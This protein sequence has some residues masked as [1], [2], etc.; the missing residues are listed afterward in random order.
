[1]L[2]S[3]HEIVKLRVMDVKL[4][5]RFEEFKTSQSPAKCSMVSPTR[6][7]VFF[8]RS[9]SLEPARQL[10]FNPQTT[11]ITVNEVIKIQPSGSFKM[12]GQI[13]WKEA[14]HLANTR[15]GPKS[16][17]DAEFSDAQEN[18]LPLV[19]WGDELINELEHGKSYNFSKLTLIHHKG[20]AKLQTLYDTEVTMADTQL[21]ITWD[22]V[23]TE[24]SKICCPDI[25]GTKLNEYRQ[26]RNKFCKKKLPEPKDG[27]V[28]VRCDHC[29]LN[30]SLKKCQLVYSIDAQIEIKDKLTSLTFFPN[31]LEEFFGKGTGEEMSQ[32]LVTFESFDI[33]YNVSQKVVTNIYDHIPI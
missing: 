10:S 21:K 26:C 33:E 24:I 29:P 20:Q 7:V 11:P 32:N 15:N 16:V 4:R 23:T 2:K 27:A 22:K 18:S 25:I 3:K 12:Q 17:R 14:K 13:M 30:M 6:S 1:M 8:N 9:S 5:D 31:I 28:S 19:V